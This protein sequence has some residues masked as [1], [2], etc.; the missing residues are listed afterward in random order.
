MR[1]RIVADR[2]RH[3]ACLG[4][5]ERHPNAPV[6]RSRAIAALYGA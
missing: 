4:A 5:I 1:C 3:V 6:A 2:L